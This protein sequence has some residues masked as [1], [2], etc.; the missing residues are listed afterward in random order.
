MHSPFG[1]LYPIIEKTGWSLHRI[2]WRESWLKIQLIMADAPGVKMVKVEEEV[3]RD[4]K[5]GLL[6]RHGKK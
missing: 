3:K 4:T 5:Q 6:A 2:L 1:T